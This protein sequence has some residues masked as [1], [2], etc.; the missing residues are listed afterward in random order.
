MGLYNVWAW[1]KYLCAESSGSFYITDW[2]AMVMLMQIYIECPWHLLF[3]NI[4]MPEE[5]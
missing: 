5:Y 4:L 2:T 1:P 3:G